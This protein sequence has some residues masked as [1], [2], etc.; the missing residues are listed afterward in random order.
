MSR[1]RLT[2]G[3]A[4]IVL[5]LAI[6]VVTVFRS[7]GKD[8]HIFGHEA[9]NVEVAARCSNASPQAKGAK[10]LELVR[11][12]WPRLGY[13]VEFLGP[14]AGY[15]AMTYTGPKLIEVYVRPCHTINQIANTLGHEFGHAADDRYNTDAERLKIQEYRGYGIRDNWFGCNRC[16]DYDTPAGD[17]AEVFAYLFS[18]KG[19]FRSTMARPPAR[20]P[21]TD[22]LI[23]FFGP[24]SAYVR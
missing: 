4:V 9:S 10:A 2:I 24:E 18:P 22:L 20:G 8:G 14:K 11:Y 1:T 19:K 23:P 7:D 15:L 21:Q 6:A 3:I 13:R 17:Y 5:I 16:T 12:P